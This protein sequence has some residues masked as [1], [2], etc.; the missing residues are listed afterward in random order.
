MAG[1]RAGSREELAAGGDG[2]AEVGGKVERRTSAAQSQ[3]EEGG[4]WQSSTSRIKGGWPGCQACHG[5]EASGRG[6][7]S[8][9]EKGDEEKEAREDKRGGG[10]GTMKGRAD[11]AELQN[12]TTT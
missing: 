4:E 2:G 11:R 12:E 5:S 1:E 3:T 8:R 9:R 7:G 6:N 10:Q